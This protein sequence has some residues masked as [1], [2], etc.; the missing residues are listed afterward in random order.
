MKITADMLEPIDECGNPDEPMQCYMCGRHIDATDVGTEW[1]LEMIDT[2]SV[3]SGPGPDDFDEV[4]L[5]PACLKRH[6]EGETVHCFMDDEKPS[7]EEAWAGGN[8][9]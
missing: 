9:K 2:S 3:E 1:K 5:C 7:F 6:E 8:C 4:V